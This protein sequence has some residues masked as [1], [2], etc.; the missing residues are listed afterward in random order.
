MATM[1]VINFTLGVFGDPGRTLPPAGCSHL[2]LR[3][4]ELRPEIARER[5]HGSPP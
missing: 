3:A 2:D 4:V 5:S 1:L